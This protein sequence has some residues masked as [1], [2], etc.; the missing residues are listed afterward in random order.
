MK[1][2]TS[3][4][5]LF[6][7]WQSSLK[8]SLSPR[9]IFTLLSETVRETKHLFWL[10]TLFFIGGAFCEYLFPDGLFVNLF[11]LPVPS[12]SILLSLFFVPYLVHHYAEPVHKKPWEY[13]LKQIAWSLLFYLGFALLIVGM[14]SALLFSPTQYINY[15]ILGYI[16]FIPVLLFFLISSPFIVLAYNYRSPKLK[17]FKSLIV[18]GSRMTLYEFPFLIFYFLYMSPV[19]FVIFAIPHVTDDIFLSSLLSH[20]ISVIYWQLG[21]SGMMLFYQQQKKRYL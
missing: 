17:T 20:Y 9:K 14:I 13:Y 1:V 11:A 15:Y 8:Y 5:S 6:Q 10:T 19:I 18:H 12:V 7:G 16:I 4:S 2:I 21:W 3:A